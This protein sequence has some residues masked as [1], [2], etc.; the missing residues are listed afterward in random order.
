MAESGEAGPAGPPSGL[1]RGAVDAVLDR[2]LDYLEE[3]PHLPRL[4]QRAGLDDAHQLRA[5]LSRLL[6]PLY[7]Q[8]LCV[9]EAIGTPWTPADHPHLAAGIYHLIFGYFANAT[10]LEV[11]VQE[12]PGSPAALARQRQFLKVAVA[13]LL[14]MAPVR[15]L[16]R[17][18]HKRSRPPEGA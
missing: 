12:D 17:P 1:A 13:E 10:L 18:A 6:R 9:L 5:T 11:V 8:G 15:R 16:P 4:I 14:G 3:H 2:I 7:A